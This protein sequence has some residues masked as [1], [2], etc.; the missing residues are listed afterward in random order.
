MPRNGTG[1]YVL[2]YNWEDDDANDIPIR[3]DRM[4]GQDQ[5]EAD[6]LTASIANDGQ[7]PILANIPWSGFRLTNVGAGQSGSDAATVIQLQ[8]NGTNYTTASGTSA[9][10]AT[11]TPAPSAYVNGQLFAVN[12][13]SAN[14]GTSA[15]VNFNGLGALALVADGGTALT[16]GDI[17]NG[18]RALIMVD[19]TNSR[20]HVIPSKLAK[21]FGLN[22][23]AAQTT[24]FTAT[25]NTRY[26]CNFVSASVI[27]LDPSATVGDAYM[28]AIAG[29]QGVT[30]DPRGAKINGSTNPLFIGT[31][32]LTLTVTFTG[33]T[34]G[35]V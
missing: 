8:T 27:Y 15:T 5:D 2:P 3:S 11:L 28:F 9:Y 33:S 35:Y 24:S 31:D 13:L 29:N 21:P 17:S 22:T 19:Q 23:G 7:T 20:G 6:A 14:V 12:F 18:L 26:V 25:V 4:Q 30:L 10:V 34:N 32:V 1:T 16:A